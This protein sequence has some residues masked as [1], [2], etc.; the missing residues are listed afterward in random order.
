[1]L[2]VVFSWL[3]LVTQAGVAASASTGTP[4]PAAG[5]FANPD[6]VTL[7]EYFP[8]ADPETGYDETIPKPEKIIG[9]SLGSALARHDLVVAWFEALAE[10]SPNVEL[11]DI[12]RTY[13][14]RRQVTAIISSVRNIDRLTE[15]QRAHLANEADAPVFTWHGYSV[16][17]NE[18]SGVQAA[19][20]V[21]WYL[22]ASRDDEVR[23]ILRNTVVMIDPSLNPDGYGRF[24]TWANHAAG[25]VHV[26]DPAHRE[27]TE[28]WPGGRGNHYFFDLN[29]DWLLLQHPETVNRVRFLQKYRP[30][31]MTDHHEMGSDQTF[32]FQPG[33]ES[34]WHPMIPT[35][36]RQLTERLAGFHARAL[37]SAK[38]LYYRGESFDDFYPGKG[39]T[40]PDLQGTVGVLFEQASSGGLVRDTAQGRITLPMAVHN[41]VLATLSTLEGSHEMAADLR[42]YRGDHQ[43]RKHVPSGLPGAWIFDDGGDPSRAAAMIEVLKGQG[44]DVFGITETVRGTN[45]N[46][47]PGRAWVVPVLGAQAPLVQTMFDNVT[48]FEDS[49]FYDVSAWSLPHAFGVRASPLSRVPS[50]LDTE[51]HVN[52]NYGISGRRNAVAW[53]LPWDDFFAPTVLA[54]LQAAGVRARVALNPFES[55]SDGEPVRFRRGAVVIHDVDVPDVDERKRDFLAR[56][57][58]GDAALVGLDSGASGS[59]PDLGSPRLRPLEPAR[60]ALLA[61]RGVNAYSA[62]SLWH[63]LD[64][65][66]GYPVSL[67]EPEVLT[68]TVLDRHTHLIIPDGEYELIREELADAIGRWTDAGGIL[69]VV[70]GAA[71]WAQTLGWLPDP[72]LEDPSR[73]RFAYGDMAAKDGA[74]QIG[75]A[76][77][78]VE[79]DETHPLAFGIRSGR[80]GLLK[81]G[82][83]ILKAPWDNPFTV[84]GAY[85]E[86][87]LISGYLPE[88][89]AGKIAD[90]PSI[91]AVPKGEGVVVAF[92]DA[93][94]FRAV[95][96]VSQRLLAN[97]ISFGNVIDTPRGTYGPA[98]NDRAE[99]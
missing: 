33:V 54:R 16:H 18:P 1:V 53:V 84:A 76:I 51:S 67:V 40:W 37:D 85:A 44:V 57:A 82:T 19:M 39:S 28:A 14:G 58:A 47:L 45:G 6:H 27:R 49:T 83:T 95:W 31:V 79:L 29:R 24:S 46:Y 73:Q 91:L 50:K 70:R 81:R 15:V 61:G 52:R 68:E 42:K 60:V 72:I 36:N 2:A 93:P 26:A 59:G 9:H 48:S 35:A 8:P 71:T 55:T 20:A 86:S 10:A 96:W 38:R 99:R 92:A 69:I 87:P 90:T 64:A 98:S 3:L 12:G 75:G 11:V 88:G 22:A 21:A 25:R 43:E 34:R 97:A 77:L 63:A 78:A 41:Q 80:V 65:R 7:L 56:I 23:E 32:F 89:F 74:Q 30:L 13:E 17:G 4:D 5:P 66:L 94:A 62:G